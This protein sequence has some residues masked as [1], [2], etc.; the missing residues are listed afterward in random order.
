MNKTL[1]MAAAAAT[2]LGAWQAGAQDIEAGQGLYRES[3]RQCHGPTAKGMGSFPRLTGK[4]AELL[5][6]RLETYRAGERV[7][8][9]S[10][11][12]MPVA[13]ELS[14]E[15]IANVTAFIAQSPN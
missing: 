9:N 7:G 11:L 2:V 8:P 1:V 14:D 12:M 3:C 10:A 4:P 15:D 5:V 6:E 13:A